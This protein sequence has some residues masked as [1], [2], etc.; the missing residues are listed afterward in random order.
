MNNWIKFDAEKPETW[1]ATSEFRLVWCQS[2]VEGWWTKARWS[3]KFKCFRYMDGREVE[4]VTYYMT[5]TNPAKPSEADFNASSLLKRCRQL[6]DRLTKPSDHV[7]V[8][9][10]LSEEDEKGIRSTPLGGCYDEQE[11]QE[12][13]EAFV[14]YFGRKS[15]ETKPSDTVRVPREFI[16]EAFDHIGE[17]DS[18]MSEWLNRARQ[19]VNHFQDQSPETKDRE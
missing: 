11:V 13:H 10:E 5:P 9:R 2:S 17:W 16:R 3:L 14:E 15:P 6:E 8:P 19:Y 7:S 12:M 1:P 18:G 4:Y